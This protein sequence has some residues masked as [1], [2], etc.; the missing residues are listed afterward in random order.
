MFRICCLI[1]LASVIIT[2]CAAQ[3][4]KPPVSIPPQKEKSPVSIPPEIVKQEPVKEQKKIEKVQAIQCKEDTIQNFNMSGILTSPFI[5]VVFFDMNG[6]GLEDMISGDKYGHLYLYESTDAPQNR[7]WKLVKGYFDGIKISAFSAPAVDDIDGDGRPEVVVG[8]GG[9]SSESGKILFFKNA[10]TDKA[11]QW[12]AVKNLNI[13]IGNDAAA[14]LVDFNFDGKPDIIAGNSEGRIFFFKNTST[15]K[16]ISF[17]QDKSIPLKKSFGMYAVPAAVKINDRVLLVIGNSLGKLYMFE[18]KKDGR[19]SE[20]KLSINA[21]AK[22]F[23]TPSFANLL[24]KDHFDIV[25]ADGDGALSYFENKNYDFTVWEKNQELFN[26][27]I[28]AGPVSAP[29][30]SYMKDRAF[31]VIGNIDGTL[32]LYEY[33]E[34]S[35]A[36]PWIERENY[37]KGIKVSG[38]SR[39]ILAAYEGNEILVTGESNGNIRAFLFA[40]TGLWKEENR[41]FS[42]VRV[43][44]HSSPVLFDLDGDGRWEIITGAEDGR[45]YA[46]RAK[47][48]KNGLPVWERITGIFDNIKVNGFSTP[49]VAKDMNVIYLIIGQQN[50]GIRAYKAESDDFSNIN[51]NK[52]VFQ[53]TDFL[54]DITMNNHSSPFMIINNGIMEIVSG[55]YDGNL[56]HFV[57]R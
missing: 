45:I 27:R 3:K 33:W 6:D 53:E 1:L 23:L 52:V 42:G 50:G 11:P 20:K 25:L 40:G 2:S 43:N 10:G 46:Y 36:L 48:I 24:K 15:K 55:D 56:R 35:N 41:F 54:R 39:G 32:K 37:F 30:V 21:S 57:C 47:E 26:N 17:K 29:T 13:K 28:F 4:E 49:A 8:T 22:R 12:E 16:N 38:F 44:Q 51:F 9:F 34:G 18:M 19:L 5:K 31:M 14:A 7:Q